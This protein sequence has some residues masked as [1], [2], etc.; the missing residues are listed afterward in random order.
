MR[1]RVDRGSPPMA[2][3]QRLT[4]ALAEQID[5]NRSAVG[6]QASFAEHRARLTAEIVARA[7]ASGGGRL[8]LL[9]AGNAYDVD[10]AALAGQFAEIHLVDVDREAVL[11]AIAGVPLT[12]GGAQLVAHAPL[13]VS[14]MFDR[15]DL[16]SRT[17]PPPG[18]LSALIGNAAEQVA[19]SLPGP[20]DVVVSCSVLTQLQLVLV[21]VVGDGNPRFEE[22]RDALNRGHMRTLGALLEPTGVG[23]LV[24]DLT[25]SAIYPPMDHLPPATDLG[26]VMSD[27]LAAGAY[28]YAAH[29]GRLTSEMRRDPQLS[30]A[31]ELHYPIGPWIWRNGP[32]QSLLVYGIE[33][34]RRAASP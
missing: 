30:R 19:G 11:R 7:P 3:P 25:G 16:W 2:R 24:T 29:P 28:I 1:V 12:D 22:L 14:G 20:F 10:L 4:A 21:Q 13:D 17:P 15:L 34:R 31:F 8:C 9:G 5:S 26:S 6:H 27:V 18:T 23:L 32:T 33:I